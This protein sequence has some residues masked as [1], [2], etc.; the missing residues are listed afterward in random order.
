[1]QNLNSSADMQRIFNNLSYL[2]GKPHRIYYTATREPPHPALTYKPKNH[3]GLKKNTFDPYPYKKQHSQL[4]HIFTQ[5]SAGGKKTPRQVWAI[6]KLL[7]RSIFD[8]IYELYVSEISFIKK[9]ESFLRNTILRNERFT[10]TYVNKEFITKTK[11]HLYP[12]IEQ[13]QFLLSNIH[14]YRKWMIHMIRKYSK[15]GFPTNIRPGTALTSK[16]ILM[17][18]NRNRRVK[19]KSIQFIIDYFQNIK[20]VM[21]TIHKDSKKCMENVGKYYESLQKF[22]HGYWFAG[23][24][25]R[26]TMDT[27]V[28]KND[29]KTRFDAIKNDVSTDFKILLSMIETRNV[30]GSMTPGEF[31][32][33]LSAY[34]NVLRRANTHLPV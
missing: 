27:S 24:Q 29:V 22:A 9:H 26:R 2:P 20:V 23:N 12:I 3:S 33:T 15:S 32:R 10:L 5:S 17:L 16:H 28:Y 30:Q 1:M 21:T 11:N 19:E 18:R 4:R 13:S 7:I 8:R 14:L 25:Q 6:I 34:H 31:E